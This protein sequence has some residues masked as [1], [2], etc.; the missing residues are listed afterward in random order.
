M[1]ITQGCHFTWKPGNTLNLKVWEKK[2][3][4]NPG[5]LDQNL[6]KTWKNLEFLTI[7]TRS[8]VKF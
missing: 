6:L 7:F 3:L 5:N 1:H 2:N 4:E 8:V